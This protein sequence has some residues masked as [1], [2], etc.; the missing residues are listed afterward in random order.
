MGKDHWGIVGEE[1]SKVEFCS[2]LLLRIFTLLRFSR[3]LFVCSLGQLFGKLR[4]L[5]RIKRFRTWNKFGWCFDENGHYD[6]K[7]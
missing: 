4:S 5:E 3:P 1:D 7:Y 6:W 2:A